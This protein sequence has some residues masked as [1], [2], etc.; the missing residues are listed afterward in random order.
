MGNEASLEG[1]EGLEGAAAA[2]DGGGPA[3]PSQPLVPAG[4]EADLSQL[5][6]EER[7]QIAAVMS[8]AQGLPRG[9]LA[10]AEP[11]PM[12]RHARKIALLPLFPSPLLRL[13]AVGRGAIRARSI[14][15][16]F[17]WR[18]EG[19]SE[20]GKGA[21]ARALGW[22]PHSAAFPTPLVSNNIGE[23]PFRSLPSHRTILCLGRGRCAGSVWVFCVYACLRGSGCPTAQGTARRA[24]LMDFVSISLWEGRVLVESFKAFGHNAFAIHYSSSS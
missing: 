2:G 14:G 11:P 6:E 22:S 9:N 3:A 10:G 23:S 16:A 19:G 8:R 15:P 5:S 24:L 13:L 4:V 21:A 18:R 7:R 20:G 12:Q 1:A 17:S